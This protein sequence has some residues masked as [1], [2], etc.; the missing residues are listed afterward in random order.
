MLTSSCMFMGDV[1]ALTR[2]FF[3]ASP[4]YEDVQNCHSALLISFAFNFFHISHQL[5]CFV[6]TSTKGSVTARE[7]KVA[8]PHTSKLFTVARGVSGEKGPYQFAV[9]RFHDLNRV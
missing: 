3:S 5:C 1:M 9:L 8:T 6:Y 2:T 4:A 7:I